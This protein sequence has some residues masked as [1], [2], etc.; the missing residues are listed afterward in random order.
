[1]CIQLLDNIE[2]NYTK[3]RLYVLKPIYI[4]M[5][6]GMYIYI[7]TQAPHFLSVD[8]VVLKFDRIILHCTSQ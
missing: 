4:Y 7:P 1:M 5:Y 3:N 2:L 6:V 8:L